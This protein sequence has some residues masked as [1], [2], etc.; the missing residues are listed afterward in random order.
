MWLLQLCAAAVVTLAT[1]DPA[2][3]TLRSLLYTNGATNSIKVGP[4]SP[5]NKFTGFHN[6]VAYYVTALYRLGAG[7]AELRAA[8][9]NASV[10]MLPPA[11]RRGLVNASSWERRIVRM[12]RARA[13]TRSR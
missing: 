12:S 8:Y 9:A 10:G 3:A 7:A 4:L 1:D 5:L 11:P 6:H 13:C 2:L